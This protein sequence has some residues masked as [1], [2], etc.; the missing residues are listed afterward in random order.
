MKKILILFLATSL[1]YGAFAQT[2]TK[3]EDKM[4]TESKDMKKN[5]V[6]MKDNKMMVCKDGETSAMTKDIKLKNG[7]TVMADGNVKTKDGKTTMMK[8]GEVMDMNGKVTW[9]KEGD[10]M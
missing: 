6:M 8:N 2:S 3:T 1:S 4:T 5:C 7:T 9:M 10:K